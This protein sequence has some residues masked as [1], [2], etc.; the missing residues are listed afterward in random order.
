MPTAELFSVAGEERT[1][2]GLMPSIF[3]IEPSEHAIYQV[4]K[5]YLT[6]QRQGN[7]STKTRGQVNGGGVKPWRQ[8]GTGRARAG[9]LSS[10]IFTGGG[11]V[12]GPI[13]HAF[14]ERTQ[15]KVRR[16]ALKSTLS[17]KAREEGLKVVEDFVLEEPKTRR[18]VEMLQACGLEGKKVLLLVSESSDAIRKSCRNIPN[19]SL[20]HIDSLCVYDVMA[21]DLVLFTRSGLAKTEDKLSL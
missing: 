5:A 9:T 10:P 18:I 12:F 4:V 6:N 14:R 13:P 2:V 21:V 3:D 1:P 20:R 11:I 15:K 16:L 7:A 17:I 19:L 8:K